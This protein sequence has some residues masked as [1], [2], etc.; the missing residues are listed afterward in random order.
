MLHN[1]VNSACVFTYYSWAVNVVFWSARRHWSERLPTQ[2]S[3]NKLQLG[4]DPNED[5][6]KLKEGYTFDEC[7]KYV[8]KGRFLFYMIE[9][10]IM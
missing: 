7:V 1:W 8:E 4:R 9:K 10:R 6:Q 5:D 2:V 3:S